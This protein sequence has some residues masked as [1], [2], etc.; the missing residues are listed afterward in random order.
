MVGYNDIPTT[1][2]W[3]IP[4]FQ[5][6]YDEAKLYASQSNK[7]IYPICP[8]CGE[9]KTKPIPISKIYKRHSIGC[10]CSDGVSYPEKFAFA[11]LKQLPINNMIFQ[12]NPEWI[13]PKR[14]DFYF[15]FNDKK[16]ILEMDGGLGHG[17][18]TFGHIDE[19]DGY[20]LKTDIKKDKL[21]KENN[22]EVIR[23]D[24]LKSQK[25]YIKN[26]ILNNKVLS[27]IIG[28][29]EINWDLCEQY[30]YKNIIKEICEYWN[31]GEYTISQLSEIFKINNAT[32]GQYLKKGSL[33][34]YCNY[35]RN[36]QINSLYQPLMCNDK[37]VF[38]SKK[39]FRRNSEKLFNV[40]ITSNDLCSIVDNMVYKG[41]K[42]EFIS[43]KFFT[44]YQ[45]QYKELTFC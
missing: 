7:K 1:D 20:G 37:Y 42:I 2:P 16:Y 26:N 39:S 18:K 25:E 44:D 33:I 32:I 3:M 27:Q 12:Y 43:Q 17:R 36:N 11:F 24:C 23:I 30:A 34:G 22:I 13:K 14:F 15:E 4:Y 28:D 38:I 35:H 6:G 41:I 10:N 21:A 8:D 9:I 5:G 31:N 19:S 29:T 45:E 40:K